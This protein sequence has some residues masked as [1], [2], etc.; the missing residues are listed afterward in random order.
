MLFTLPDDLPQRLVAFERVAKRLASRIQVFSFSPFQPASHLYMYTQALVQISTSVQ[1]H[2]ILARVLSP[3][4]GAMRVRK[5][6]SACSVLRSTT[7]PI[8]QQ[9]FSRRRACLSV[10]LSARFL[11]RV[12]SCAESI[13]VGVVPV[14]VPRDLRGSGAAR[15]ESLSFARP[16]AEM[17]VSRCGT[18]FFWQWYG[19]PSVLY[20][21]M[22]GN[23]NIRP[24]KLVLVPQDSRTCSPELC[25][26][27]SCIFWCLFC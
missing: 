26:F 22:A 15:S 17:C 16:L 10:C 6:E 25:I 12:L 20:V 23:G 13:N 14:V 21:P 11:S 27:L 5:E 24:D 9:T 18:Y 4:F 3:P 7:N 19:A 1:K 8:M 2:H